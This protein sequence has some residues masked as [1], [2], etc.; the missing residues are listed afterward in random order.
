LARSS[1]LR[2]KTG[3]DVPYDALI[4]EPALAEK[5]EA[6]S[7]A[8][9]YTFTIRKGMKWPD[10]PPLSGREFTAADVKWSYE[11]YS[12]TGELKD[13]GLPPANLSAL[14]EGLDRVDTSDPYTVVVRFKDP[15][16]P[17]ITT[18]PQPT[19][20]TSPRSPSDQAP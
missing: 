14:F 12:R 8:R 2:F 5:W 3:P 4:L 7:D 18:S 16:A 11:Y 15:F 10:I 1:V 19:N 13:K 6:S 17:F 9:T 20:L